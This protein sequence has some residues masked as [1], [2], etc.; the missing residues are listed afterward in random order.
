[1]PYGLFFET[2]SYMA[3]AALGFARTAPV[4]FML[5][6][7][8][9]NVLSGIVRSSVII[10]V[11]V[12]VWPFAIEDIASEKELFNFS[13]FAKEVIIGLLLGCLLSWP[14]WVFHALGCMFDN[15]RGA[16]LSSSIDPANGVDTSEMANFLN[17]FSAAIYLQNDG[18]LV[19]LE[20]LQYS[21][22][23]CHPATDCIPSLPPLLSF[24]NRITAKSLILASP[25]LVVLLLAEMMLGLLSRF[26]PQMNAFAV[27]LTVKSVLALF[28]LLVYFSPML[29]T[30]V[31][32]ISSAVSFS[33]IWV[34]KIS[35]YYGE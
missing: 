25:V 26:A 12:S 23:L 33:D 32:E 24:I 7:L 19:I 16:T 30:S 15:Q 3:H 10:L 22:Q 29:S 18:M 35:N 28:V 2:Q 20:T 27:S 6:F 8:N 34:H 13:G 9:N 11:A 21:Y 1:M 14:F 17:F 5:P 31:L 4:F